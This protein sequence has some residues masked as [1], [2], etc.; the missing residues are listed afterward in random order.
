MLKRGKGHLSFHTPGHKDTSGADI[1]ELSYSDCLASP[2]GVLAKTEGEIAE[3][4]GAD[5]SFL[6]TDGST[7]GIFSMIYALRAAGIKSVAVPVFSHPSVRHACEVMGIK[8]DPIPQ[9]TAWGIPQQPNEEALRAAKRSGAIL[10]T[11]PDYYGFFPPLA[12]AKK[13]A[14]EAGIPLLLDGAHGSHLHGTENY[15]GRFAD[16]WVDGVHKSLPALT[17][18]AVVS[19][20]GKW[21]KF[22]HEGVLR[23]RT[24]SPSYP[25]MASVEYAVKYPR[26]LALEEASARFKRR[27]GCLENGDW[28]KILVPFGDKCESACSLLEEAGIYPEFS[29]GNYLMFYLS[30]CTE[31]AHLERLGALLDGLERGEV[32]R[33]APTGAISMYTEEL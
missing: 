4:L 22:L 28:T 12:A 10:L 11:S 33:D 16:L 29:D 5:R 27:H 24:T 2:R 32:R 15:A 9:I 18:G 17:Q 14:E 6:L 7:S 21:G 13:I 25:I 3:I 20:K 23:F 31:Q 30:P 19:A 26:N 8:T 1:T